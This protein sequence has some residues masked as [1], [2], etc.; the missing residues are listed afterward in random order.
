MS[1]EVKNISASIHGRLRNLARQKGM[2]FQ[3]I[4][5]YYA[6]ERLLYRL[7][8]SRHGNSF[9]L[10]G[11]LMFFGWGVPL[12]RPTRDIDLQGYTANTIENLVEI[13]RDVCAIPVDLPDGMTYDPDSVAGERIMEN[14][15][16]QGLR[17][18]VTSFLGQAELKFH[19]DVS[20]AQIITPGVVIVDYPTLLEM[21]SFPIRGYPYETSIS[22]KLHVMVAQDLA[23]TRMKDF[24]DIW[25]LAQEFHIQ[26][27]A[28]VDAITNTFHAHETEIPRDVL[29]AFTNR[30]AIERRREWARIQ[31]QTS[32]E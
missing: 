26:G 20:F 5:Y 31:E 13:I 4:H 19:L 10:K 17:I 25:L 29:T 21:P 11:G 9:V 15:D 1:R 7:F 22:E 6:L 14:F 24:Y 30:F 2:L 16:Y 23:N 12:R 27:Q 8:Q 28:L 3:Q 32:I 18:H